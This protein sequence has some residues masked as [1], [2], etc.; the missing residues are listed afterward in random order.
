[1]VQQSGAGGARLEQSNEKRGLS[2]LV[3]IPSLGRMDAGSTA[4]LRREAN[5]ITYSSAAATTEATAATPLI[6]R[7]LATEGEGARRDVGTPIPDGSTLDTVPAAVHAAAVLTPGLGPLAAATDMIRGIVQLWN[8]RR[9]NLEDL[10]S[11]IGTYIRTVP[12][13]ALAKVQE[14][15]ASF[16][17]NVATATSCIVG[18]VG[19]F[20]PVSPIT[21]WRCCEASLP[22]CWSYR[23]SH[24]ACRASSTT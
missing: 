4:P 18:E 11:G 21:G 12:A 24:A 17:S 10:I 1:M 6:Q 3:P 5:P 19:A 7:Q 2:G 23:C 9:A 15:A 13:A 22:T 20:L 14:Y 8:R 16:G